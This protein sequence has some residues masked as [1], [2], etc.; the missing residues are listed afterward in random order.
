MPK[1]RQAPR[2]GLLA[3]SNGGGNGFVL[4]EVLL[5]MSLI[6]GVWMALVGTYQNLALR[7]AQEESKRA[8]LKK[9]ADAFEISEHVRAS[10]TVASKGL[11]HESSRVPSR[12]RAIP[13]ASKPTSQK[14]R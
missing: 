6:V 2:K 5:A 8:Q 9:E 1:P 11:S 7:N 10:I 14:Q 4:L 3:D 13:V 12:N